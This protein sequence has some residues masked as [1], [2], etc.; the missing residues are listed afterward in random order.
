MQ[1]NVFVSGGTGYIGR[2]LISRL[3][4]GG[5]KVTALA[6]E[7]S[8]SKLPS[9]CA[10]VLGD[11]LEGASFAHAVAAGG[12]FVHLVGVAH[13]APW[14]AAQFRS[15]DLPALKA[16]AAAAL[17]ARVRHFVFVSVA[18][19][20]PLMKAYIAVRRECEDILAAT[21]LRTT[22]LR[23]WYVLGPGH[24]WPALLRPLYALAEST[25]HW[26][27]ALRLGLVTREEMVGALA[28]ALANPPHQSRILEVPEIRFL[29]TSALP[30]IRNPLRSVPA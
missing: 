14:K 10:V 8:E 24:R 1:P 4:S 27:T 6:R 21:G 18:H 22:I 19:P 20:A 2:E 26:E 9:G 11:A 17:K 29:S 23:P 30:A 13:P 25:R 7:G 3:G 28:W 12:T 15:V 16:S 5:H